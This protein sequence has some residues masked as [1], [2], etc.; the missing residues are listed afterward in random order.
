MIDLLI[1]AIIAGLGYWLWSSMSGRDLTLPDWSV[2]GNGLG[3]IGQTI[4][5]YG[6]AL[7]TKWGAC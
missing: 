5:G 4:R 7:C 6:S 3:G 2:E 1:L